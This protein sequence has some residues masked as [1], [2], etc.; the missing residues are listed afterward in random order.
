MTKVWLSLLSWPLASSYFSAPLP[1]P[2]TSAPVVQVVEHQLAKTPDCRL[3]DKGDAVNLAHVDCVASTPAFQL[4]KIP[5]TKGKAFEVW[6][7]EIWAEIATEASPV[8]HNH[9]PNNNVEEEVV[10]AT[11]IEA[12]EALMCASSREDPPE[13]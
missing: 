13:L 12:P 5:S 8:E 7:S 6:V 9:C 2:S 4:A 11:A 1:L 10:P 3:D